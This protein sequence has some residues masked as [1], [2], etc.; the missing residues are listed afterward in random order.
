MERVLHKS[1]DRPDKIMTPNLG[2]AE[3]LTFENTNVKA[4]RLTLKA[5][6]RWSKDVSPIAGTQLCQNA[7]RGFVISGTICFDFGEIQE[8]VRS[9]EAFFAPGNHD[10]FVEGGQEVIIMAFEESDEKEKKNLA[11]EN[12]NVSRQ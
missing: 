3:I 10:A 12:A 1:F 11:A 5:G 7:L 8:I 9:G 6:W 2:R 4:V